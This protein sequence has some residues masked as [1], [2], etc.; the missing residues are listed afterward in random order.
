MGVV[1]RAR[2]ERLDRDI[3]L[4][5]LPQGSLADEKGRTRFKQEALALSRL[6]HPNIATIHDFDVDGGVDFLVMEYVGGTPVDTLIRAGGLSQEAVPLAE[7][8]RQL[9]GDSSFNFILGQAYFYTGQAARAEE[10]L[11]AASGTS[12]GDRRARALLASIM[13]A[14]HREREAKTLLDAVRAAPIDHHIADNLATAYAQLREPGEAMKWL[15]EAARTGLPCYPWYARDP[16]LDPLRGDPS[17]KSFWR[18]SGIH[19]A[20]MRRGTDRR[21][22]T[23][24]RSG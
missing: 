14:Q 11:R 21:S 15:A 6:N 19:G 18:T 8:V 9:V 4:K 24:C 16:L 3:A 10:V 17:F 22:Q 7:E 12:T 13:A 20:P 1:Y 5:L 23:D 2:D